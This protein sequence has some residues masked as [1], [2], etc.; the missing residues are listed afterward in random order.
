MNNNTPEPRDFD[1]EIEEQI[2]KVFRVTRSCL[3]I[4]EGAIEEDAN[5]AAKFFKNFWDATERVELRRARQ[6]LEE[7][8]RIE[9]GESN[10]IERGEGNGL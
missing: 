9:R 8:N 2:G 6:A 5:L 1:Q 3:D 4:I 7:A 10:R